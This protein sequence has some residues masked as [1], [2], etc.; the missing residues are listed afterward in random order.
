MRCE[1]RQQL[2][3]ARVRLRPVAL[4]AVAPAPRGRGARGSAGTRRTGSAP[5]SAA[6]SS[7]L[8]RRIVRE[9]LEH[10]GVLVAEQELDHAVLQRLEARRRARARRGIPGIRDGVSVSSTAH[11]SNS[12]R[13]TCLTRARIFRHGVDVVARRCAIAARSSWIISFIHSS[14]TWCW[15]MNSISSWCGGSR[16]RLLRG[17][18]AVQLQVAAVGQC[19][20]AGRVRCPAP[21]DAGSRLSL[22]AVRRLKTPSLPSGSARLLRRALQDAGRSCVLSR[23]RIRPFARA[24]LPA[25]CC[26]CTCVRCAGTP[27][28]AATAA[29]LSIA[30]T[31]EIEYLQYLDAGRQARARRPARVRARH[32]ASWSSCTS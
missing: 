13:W 9:H 32:H 4:E 18:A 15:M 22:I 17:R 28:A 7:R 6:R 10:A 5:R 30:A 23:F 25:P 29:V 27:P 12:W 11:C 16:Q 21:G 19:G 8:R 26:A 3:V 1:H 2:G 14:A 24:H 20:R 31:F